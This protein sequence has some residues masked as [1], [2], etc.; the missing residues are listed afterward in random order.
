MRPTSI[1]L[2]SALIGL[3]VY[4][5]PV[6]A[7]QANLAGIVDWHKPL[8]GQPLLDPTPPSILETPEGR[9]IVSITKSNVFSLLDAPTGDIGEWYF[10]SA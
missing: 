6:L 3:L 5:L 10:A 2:L 8:I 9:R 4:V 1:P 7:L